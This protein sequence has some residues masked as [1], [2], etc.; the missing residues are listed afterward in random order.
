[1][2]PAREEILFIFTTRRVCTLDEINQCLIGNRYFEGLSNGDKRLVIRR[3]VYGLKQEN[4]IRW[5]ARSTYEL[6]NMHWNAD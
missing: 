2:M 3:S 4:L 1:M 6:V 5:I